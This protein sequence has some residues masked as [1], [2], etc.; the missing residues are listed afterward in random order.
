M[1]SESERK[2]RRVAHK[3]LVKRKKKMTKAKEQQEMLAKAREKRRYR[4][5]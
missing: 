1:G 2:K 3:E 5:C 4:G